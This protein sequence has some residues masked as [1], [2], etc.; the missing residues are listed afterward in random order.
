MPRR[1]TFRGMRTDKQIYKIPAANPGWFFEV[2]RITDPGRCE[3]RSVEL[4]D[5]A[6]TADGVIEPDA[7]EQ[8]LFVVEFQSQRD[9]TVR[10]ALA[11]IQ[12]SE[13][14][15][16]LIRHTPQIESL[17]DFDVTTGAPEN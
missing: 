5:I 14:I 8:P 2:T 17:D 13:Q 4:K 1:H 9:E 7:S 6:L 10:Q 3:F 15:N 16:E 11:A 12:S